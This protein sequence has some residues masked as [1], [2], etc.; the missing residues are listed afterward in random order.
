MIARNEE[1]RTDAVQSDLVNP[2]AWAL[3]LLVLFLFVAIYL[4]W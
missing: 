4:P 1:Q 2:V 3:V